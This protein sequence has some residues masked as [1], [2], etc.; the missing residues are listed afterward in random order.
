MLPHLVFRLKINRTFLQVLNKKMKSAMLVTNWDNNA[1]GSIIHL[2]LSKDALSTIHT[3]SALI[4]S[5]YISL[6]AI[7]EDTTRIYKE[8]LNWGF[9][10]TL[11]VSSALI[12]YLETF[13][14]ARWCMMAFIVEGAFKRGPI[15]RTY[16][17]L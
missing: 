9:Y 2:G 4:R 1:S 6:D 7:L 17:I 13:V 15:P 10:A 3:Y 12:N 5:N 11:R 14:S 8:T 16:N